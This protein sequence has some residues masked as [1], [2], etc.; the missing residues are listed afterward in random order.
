ME[1]FLF[2]DGKP[3]YAHP[4]YTDI[5][6]KNVRKNRDS[7]LQLFMMTPGEMV[8][9]HETSGDPVYLTTPI[10]LLDGTRKANTGY[11]LRKGLGNVYYREGNYGTE[12]CPVFRATEAYL[13]YLEAS[14]IENGGNSID[15]TA[16]NYWKQLRKRAG[17]PEDYMIT[18]NA[19]VFPGSI[20]D[21]VKYND[22]PQTFETDWAVY[23]AGK[24][25]SKLM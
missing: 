21:A 4:E 19:T 24:Q 2:R 12:A 17:L 7:R 10:N 11:M 16:E 1:T 5:S 22:A 20:Q 25:V 18:V 9:Y 15:A 3:I 13:N 8:E 6:I 23:S 14:C